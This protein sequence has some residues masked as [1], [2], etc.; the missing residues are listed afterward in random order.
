MT[1]LIFPGSSWSNESE[2]VLEELRVTAVHDPPYISIQPLP[3]G[4]YIFEGYLYDVWQVIAQALH[5]RYRLVPLVDGGFGRLDENGTWTG[6]VGELTYGRADVALA[7][8]WMRKD[9]LAVVDYLEVPVEK[10]SDRFYFSKE[11]DD[12]PDLTSDMFNSLLRPLHTHVWW[13]LLGSLLVLS[14][15]LRGTARL[16]RGQDKRDESETT[17]ASCLF[18]NFMS[19]VGQG[20]T[21]MPSSL[22]GRT[23]TIFTWFLCIIISNSYTAILISNLTVV[24]VHRPINSLKEFTEQSDWTLT[25][26]PDHIHLND[27]KSSSNKYERELYRRV[28][29]KNQFIP[30]YYRTKE[31]ALGS[32]KPN[33]LT[34]VNI[35]RMFYKLQA[36]ACSLVPLY[37]EPI[38]PTNYN[39]MVMAKGK[40]KL[41]RAMNRVMKKAAEAGILLILKKRWIKRS[42]MCVST[43]GAKPIS[44]G[45]SFALLM[46]LLLGC[47]ASVIVILLEWAWFK[48]N[49]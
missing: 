10:S 48:R 20:W 5:I 29:N 24:T 31:S 34:Y 11:L 1:N 44:F 6:M 16:C 2:D 4:S 43:L 21:S 14:L 33:M 7:W 8:L 23:V 13:A 25:M 40:D 47:V 26:A 42:D 19:L 41:R 30:F 38:E 49:T 3:D 32:I 36:Q 28:T 9:R 46:I 12:T 18:S 35:D 15:A 37:E 39:Y 22:S 17:W 27:W 45:N